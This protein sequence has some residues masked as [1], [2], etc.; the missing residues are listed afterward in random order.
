MDH[1]G[2]AFFL[3]KGSAQDGAEAPAGLLLLLLLLDAVTHRF[4][5]LRIGQNLGCSEEIAPSDIILMEKFWPD[6]LVFKHAAAL[7]LA[8]VASKVFVLIPISHDPVRPK[9][10]SQGI[11]EVMA[12]VTRML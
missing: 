4:W 9:L 6:Y 7:Q 10:V 2:T 8:S 12:R 3:W 11:A 5:T 1:N